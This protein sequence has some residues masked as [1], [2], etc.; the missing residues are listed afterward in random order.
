MFGASI[1]ISPI[2]APLVQRKI[3]RG[4][5]IQPKF[6]FS[7]V[8][9]ILPDFTSMDW[10]QVFKI[11]DDPALKA[12]REKLWQI[13]QKVYNAEF[14]TPADLRAYVNDLLI[15]ELVREVTR[16]VPSKRKIGI[17][18]FLGSIPNI[19]FMPIGQLIT[20]GKSIRE[21]IEHKRTWLALFMKLRK[22][23]R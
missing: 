15:Q 3:K 7:I 18:S 6:H 21:L 2:Y 14:D 4:Q 17:D 9:I 19:A 16:L 12:L 1:S 11:R 5:S 10:E 13:N 8:D 20:T 23:E 22:V